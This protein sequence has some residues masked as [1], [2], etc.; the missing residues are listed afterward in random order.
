MKSIKTKFITFT[1]IITILCSA[2]IGGIT[3]KNMSEL[4]DN[5]SADVLNLLVRESASD[6]NGILGR[7]EQSV[8]VLADC[9]D[10]YVKTSN[11]N[12]EAS[13][14]DMISEYMDQIL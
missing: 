13:D 10:D 1:L 9:I 2:L 6:L 14:L 11:A 4:S 12:P 7:I 3:I 5:A 8:E